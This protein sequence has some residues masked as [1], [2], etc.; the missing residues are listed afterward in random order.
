VNAVAL[1]AIGVPAALVARMLTVLVTL[2]CAGRARTCRWV[3]LG[4]SMAASVL[5]VA[6]AIRV[7]MSGQSVDGALVRHAASGIVLAYAVTPLSA[8]FLLVLGL[9]AVPVAFYS[10]GYFA[11]AVRPSRTA[12]VGVAFNV[13]LGA[14]EIVFVAD[15]V[16]AFLFAWEIMTL[17]TAALVA[18]EHQERSTR[19][20][21][22][23]YLVMS[24]VGTGCLVAGFLVLAAASGSVA[25]STMLAG[26]VVSGSVRDGLFVLFL[27]GFGV[28]AGLI[29]LHVWLPEAH[30]AAPS[31]I[32]AL[33][34]AVLITAGLYGL[35]KVCAFG[36]GVPTMRWGLT[37]MAIGTLS[38]ILGVLYALTQ[39]DVK[40]LLAYSTIENAGI[41][42]LALGAAMVA[43]AHDRADLATVAI[44]ASLLHMLNHAVFKGLLFL[45]VGSVVMTTGTREIE[46]FGGLLR[47]MPWTGLCFLV[48]A[49][50]IS[51]LPLLNGF[52]SEWLTFQALLVGFASTPGLVRLN[53]PLGGAMLALTTALAAACFVRMFGISFLALPRS[54]SASQAREA[55]FVMLAPQVFLAALCV[56]LGLFPGVALRLLGGVLASLPGVAAH[57]HLAPQAIGMGSTLP[58]FDHVVPLMLAVTVLAALAGAALLTRRRDVHTRRVPTWGC[59]GELTAQAEYTATAFSKPLLMIFKAVYRPTREV[60]ALAEVSPYFPREVRYRA[61]IEPTFERYVYGP[62]LRAVLR[63]ANGMRVL[64]AGSLHAYLAYVLAFGVLLLLWLGGTS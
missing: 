33:M 9:V 31:S 45:G 18:T 43:L 40:R 56:A 48:G 37:C 25:F 46:Q 5:T 1:I 47:R 60:E 38:A 57:T 64:Q 50:A 51:G 16:I 7:I 41:I 27:L 61:A 55:P 49:M 24:H 2:L 23:L 52:T 42:V 21:A 6:V 3:A 10:A 8:W 35:F 44:A 30:P 39:H 19:R 53:F 22:Y 13:M 36:L 54:E 26:H 4:G 29:P 59:G 62:L 15:S 32:S 17:A 12:V 28:K 14:V 58:S 11:H 63:I 34:S 20:A